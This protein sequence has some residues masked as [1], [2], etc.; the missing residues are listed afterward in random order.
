MSDVPLQFRIRC[1]ALRFRAFAKGVTSRTKVER[2]L[3]K[4]E[5][6]VANAIAKALRIEAKKIAKQL[7]KGYEQIMKASKKINALVDDVDADGVG[8]IVRDSIKG[9]LVQTFKRAGLAAVAEVEVDAGDDITSHLDEAALDFAKERGAELVTSVSRT[10]RDELRELTSDAVEEG[11]SP[12]AF[13][14]TIEDAVSFSDDRAMMIARTELAY[15]H[16][17]GNL[18]GYKQ[19][20]VVGGKRWIASQ[21]AC[22]LC[23]DMDNEEVSLEESFDFDGEEIDGPPGHP[24]CRCDV[25]AVLNEEGE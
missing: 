19:S 5:K 3:E 8:L 13:A 10:T 17:A 25:V 1:G 21:D 16:V 7:S 4:E 18:E 2:F 15:S 20:G 9:S 12:A 22:P 14:R 11:L 23:E 6:P 24:N